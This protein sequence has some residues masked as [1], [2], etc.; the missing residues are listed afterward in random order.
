MSW[1][2]D[3]G[4]IRKMEPDESGVGLVYSWR[5]WVYPKGQAS[6]VAALKKNE[7]RQ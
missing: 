1:C 5:R 3:C 7:A 2:P 4:A 6:A